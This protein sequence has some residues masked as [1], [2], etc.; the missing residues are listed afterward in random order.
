MGWL[1][2]NW[3][4]WAALAAIVQALVV[5]AALIYARHQLGE[6]TRSRALAATSQLLSE[7]GE[8]ELRKLRH[9]VLYQ[10]SPGLDFSS[11]QTDQVE[12]MTS[13]A[14]RYDRVGYMT[15]Q[16]LMPEG[17][18]FDFQGDE[19]KL[20]WERIEPVI[21]HYREEA[22]PKRPNYCMSF[23]W[24]ATEWLPKMKKMRKK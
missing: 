12:I 2:S 18:L 21:R 15:K 14:V 3:Q 5:I 22:D 23:R 6:A 7:I 8:P 11:L 24:L 19:I 10:I 9:L 17:A 13:V 20:L 4:D 1:P 16:K